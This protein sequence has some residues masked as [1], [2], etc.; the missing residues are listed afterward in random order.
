METMV[1]NMIF[2]LYYVIDVYVDLTLMM[3]YIQ[4]SFKESYHF[5]ILAK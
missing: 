1:Q 3:K 2:Y 5:G 4:E